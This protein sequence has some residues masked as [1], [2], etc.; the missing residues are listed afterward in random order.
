MNTSQLKIS[1][2]AE[3]DSALDVLKMFGNTLC[4]VKITA[5]SEPSSEPSWVEEL[6]EAIR[7]VEETVEKYNA[8]R[9]AAQKQTIVQY[10][11]LQNAVESI[12]RSVEEKMQQPAVDTA[13][14]STAEADAIEAVAEVVAAEVAAEE[15]AQEEEVVEEE[16]AAEEEAAEEEAA[17]EEVV[18]E[19]EA[20]EEEAAEEEEEGLEEFEYKGTTYYKDSENTVYTLDEEDQPIPYGIWNETKKLIM[21]YKTTPVKK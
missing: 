13:S 19:E 8:C 15:A 11:G 9:L 16:E 17:E 10:E 4:D 18:E 6:R 12:A 7:R 21:P 5:S 2:N 3:G 20:V 14:V 1:I